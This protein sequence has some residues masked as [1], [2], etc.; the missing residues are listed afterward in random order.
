MHGPMSVKNL[1]VCVCLFVNL[2][3][4]DALSEEEIRRQQIKISNGRIVSVVF[5]RA[6]DIIPRST[7]KPSVCR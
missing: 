6:V 5:V 4:K 2:S 7:F 1:C 3:T